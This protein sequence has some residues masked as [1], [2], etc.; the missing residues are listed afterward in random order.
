[1]AEGTEARLVT[2]HAVLSC[3]LAEGAHLLR[4]LVED[5]S[6]ADAA[7]ATA[8]RIVLQ[9]NGPLPAGTILPFEVPVGAI[10]PSARYSVRAHLDLS[11]NG[12]IEAGDLISTQSHP[13]LTQGA[14]DGAEVRLLPA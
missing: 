4:V 6:R 7:A 12:R 11:G 10:D 3:P 1:M 14:P 8:G 9:V 5:V 13:V 2:G